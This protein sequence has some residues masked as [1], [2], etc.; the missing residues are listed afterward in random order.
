MEVCVPVFLLDEFVMSWAPASISAVDKLPSQWTFDFSMFIKCFTYAIIRFILG[1]LDTFSSK[2]SMMGF[3]IN[4]VVHAF[5]DTSGSDLSIFMICWFGMINGS[6][7]N[8]SGPCC[9][10]LSCLPCTANNPR[11]LQ[12]VQFCFVGT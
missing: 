7:H 2:W 4:F 11:K 8:N 9:H 5:N 12:S 1:Q 3:V 6:L 10:I